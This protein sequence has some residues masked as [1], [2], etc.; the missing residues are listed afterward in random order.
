MSNNEYF[1]KLPTDR[2]GG[3]I[4][5]QIDKFYD[6]M[7]GS[8][9]FK[10]QY[11]ASMHYFG[12]SPSS[13]NST[14][15][16]RPGGKNGQLALVKIN[17]LRNLAQHLIQLT[18]S[19]KP[20]PDPIATNTDAKSQQ[21]CT[22]ARGVLDYYSREKRVD[23]V[24]R[25]AAEYAVVG[26][27]GFVLTTWQSDAVQQIGT[28]ETSSTGDVTI[29]A[30]MS[31]EVIRDPS[32]QSFESLDWVI[33]REWSSK[34]VM[35]DKWAPVTRDENTGEEQ[36]SPI[37]ERILG[38]RTRLEYDRTRMTMMNWMFNSNLFGQSDDIAIYTFWHKKSPSVPEG[39]M[40]I[41]LEDGTVLEDIPLPYATVPVRRIAPADIA[42]SPFGYTAIFDLLVIQ[43]VIDS[44]YSAVATNQMTFGVQL[45][46]AMKGA[47]LD[48]K[49]LARG[50]SFI[51]YGDP[52]GKPEAL[53]LTHTPAEVFKF[54]EQLEKA[55]ETISGVNAIVRGTV[56]NNDMSGSAMA[57]VQSQ[58]ISFSSGLQ[59]SYAHLVEDTFTDILGIIK[60]Y[61]TDE[62]VIT[63]V[64]KYNRSMLVSFQGSQIENVNRVVVQ[65]ESAL[66]QTS[67]GRREMAQDLIKSGLIRKPEEYIS[68]VKTGN[69]D[70]LLEG[71]NSELIL[72]RSEN[73]NMSNGQ[74]T[75]AVP[76]DEHALHIKE[77]RCVLSTPESRQNPEILRVITDHIA[78]HVSFLADPGLTNLLLVLGQQPLATAAMPDVGQGYAPGMGPGSAPPG[79]TPKKDDAGPRMPKNP[80]T[81]QKWNP[82]DGG[83]QVTPETTQ[84]NPPGNK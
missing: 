49:Q 29:R 24:L 80:A 27:D 8:G 73:E 17:H 60:N 54:I 14:E 21:Q 46:M 81:G 22:L 38:S 48:F 72:I 52:M 74:P 10:R 34:F 79:N 1:A 64:G 66:A 76:T 63:I 25:K 16:V 20:S 58:A 33:T 82:Q 47:D 37:R 39:R 3:E 51:E 32:K 56:P 42:D 41:C 77:H 59:Q 78:Q 69:L 28:A 68:V 19:Q 11:K 13:N 6:F 23:R 67:A 55:M 84:G 75:F 50:L 40:V 15:S 65:A 61:V 18:T 12:V 35:A 43:E 53:N 62:K 2:V 45:I 5:N 83:G 4:K 31:S 7:N 9:I 36:F 57:L 71:E 44:L 26:G 70:P 30:L